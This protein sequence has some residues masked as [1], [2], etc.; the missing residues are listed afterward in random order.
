MRDQLGLIGTAAEIETLASS[1]RDNGGCYIVPAFSGLFAPYWRSDARG[2][3]TGLTRG[4]G[5]SG[6]SWP[7]CRRTDCQCGAVGV[8]LPGAGAKSVQDRNEMRRVT[9]HC[10]A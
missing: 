10:P 7:P 6:R 3:I 5:D 1:V 2:V 9:P 8:C 4:I